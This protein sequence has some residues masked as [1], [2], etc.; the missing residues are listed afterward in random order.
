METDLRYPIGKF[1][2]PENITGDQRS[3]FIAQIADAP[4][5]LAAAVAGLKPATRCALSAGRVDRAPGRASCPRQSHE[6][7]RSLQTCAH[8]E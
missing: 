5:G 1:E 6:R 8:R 3:Q 7:V 2:R 4:A